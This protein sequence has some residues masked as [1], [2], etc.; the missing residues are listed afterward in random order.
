MAAARCVAV[1]HLRTLAGTVLMGAPIWL[2]AAAIAVGLWG[3]TLAYWAW[4]KWKGQ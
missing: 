4:H 2:P 3:G 1:H